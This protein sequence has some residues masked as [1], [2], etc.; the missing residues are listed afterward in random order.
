MPD[1]YTKYE[2]N[3]DGDLIDPPRIPDFERQ[4]IEAGAL[5]D[6]LLIESLTADYEEKRREMA[7]RHNKRVDDRAEEDRRLLAERDERTRA[8]NA[9]R[10]QDAATQ[11]ERDAAQAERENPR[12]PPDAPPADAPAPATVGG[13][14]K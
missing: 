9:Q 4:L 7:E 12:T 13:E 2:Y 6:D 5:G 14:N 3:D 1:L 11:R 8:E 10:A